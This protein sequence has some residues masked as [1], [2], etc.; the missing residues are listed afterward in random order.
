MPS[1]IPTFRPCSLET[2]WPPIHA[3]LATICA[4][5]PRA[6]QITVRHRLPT[7]FTVHVDTS[8]N[9]YVVLHAQCVLHLL[10]AILCGEKELN[11]PSC[12]SI[13]VCLGCCEANVS[14]TLC[15]FC[16]RNVD[17]KTVML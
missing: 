9:C 5:R 13:S 10:L 2:W 7:P 17:A 6:V 16:V 11:R 12:A 14:L 1:R 3:R 4:S 8:D 15:I